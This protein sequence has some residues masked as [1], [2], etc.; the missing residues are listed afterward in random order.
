LWV[1]TAGGWGFGSRYNSNSAPSS[2]CQTTHY[3][4]TQPTFNATQHAGASNT[5]SVTYTAADVS[6][7]RNPYSWSRIAHVL[8]IDSPAGTGMSYSTDP[9]VR[10]HAAL[11]SDAGLGW[12]WG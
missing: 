9:D 1:G 8:Y 11:G 12:G 10:L 3:T 2:L 7:T 4:Y 5:Q 6:L